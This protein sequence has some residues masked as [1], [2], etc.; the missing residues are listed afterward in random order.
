MLKNAHLKGKCT[1]IL[2]FIRSPNGGD[3]E[4]SI[5]VLSSHHSQRHSRR[6]QVLCLWLNCGKQQVDSIGD[7][8]AVWRV[9]KW[10]QKRNRSW[11]WNSQNSARPQSREE[12]VF[13]SIL[14]MLKK[15]Q[16]LRLE[17]NRIC[18]GASAM[19]MMWCCIAWLAARSSHTSSSKRFT[20]YA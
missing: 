13:S 18:L 16:I 14:P 19:A 20:S 4:Y 1:A 11:T 2:I 7:T 17:H 3:V 9:Q 5:S 12:T 10:L 8:D 15:F 6:N